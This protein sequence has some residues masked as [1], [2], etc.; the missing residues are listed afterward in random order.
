MLAAS[1]CE[2]EPSIP[3]SFA[4]TA[5]SAVAPSFLGMSTPAP[6]PLLALGDETYVLLTTTR[7][8]GVAVPTAVWVGRDGDA[9][10]VTTA[11][12]AGKTKRI[13]HT[14]RVTLQACDRA[15]N[16]TAGAPIVEGRAVVDDSDAARDRL[17]A[18]F[19]RK[20][21]ATY[22]AIRAMARL[23]GRSRSASVVLRIMEP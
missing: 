22:A 14:P 1:R 23:R 2:L 4:R 10:V 18:L 16:P 17:D 5:R 19:R 9:L 12:D 6:S 8:S 20:Y 3:S 21:G 15:G 7:R 11:A 13:R